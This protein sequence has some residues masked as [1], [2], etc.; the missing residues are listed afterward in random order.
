[1]HVKVKVIQITE[2]QEKTVKFITSSRGNMRNQML[3]NPITGEAAGKSGEPSYGNKVF[4][5]RKKGNNKLN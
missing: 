3:N 1:M 4:N 5:R 2:K